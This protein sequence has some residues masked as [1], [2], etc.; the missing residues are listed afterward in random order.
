MYRTSE[1]VKP[2]EDT[3]KTV[4]YALIV[5]MALCFISNN[6]YAVKDLPLQDD[7]DGGDEVSLM[8]DPDGGDEVSGADTASKG[9]KGTI[10]VTV[11]AA[12]GETQV[13]SDPD[14]GDEISKVR[15]SDKKHA[16]AMNYVKS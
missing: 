8:D 2:K 5:M 11:G 13:E 16:E 3:L 10:N 15:T 12:V 6:A 1:Q 7:P 4:R 9:T 14:G